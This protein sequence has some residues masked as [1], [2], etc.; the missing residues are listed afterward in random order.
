MHLYFFLRGNLP[1]VEMFKTLAQGQ[2]WQ[3][4]RTNI[5][6]NKEETILVQGVLRPSVFG[7]YEYVFPEES[8]PE[9]LS[10]LGY[11]GEGIPALDYDT[12]FKQFLGRRK[13]SI[14]RKIFG[15]K[16]IPK[17]VF[18]VA[19][20]I[21][22]SIKLEGGTRGLSHLKIPGVAVHVIG[23]KEDKRGEFFHDLEAPNGFRQE[24]L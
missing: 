16:A 12:A 7:S 22:H 23:I 4:K 17:K 3:W 19:K 1:C 20:L 2:Y 21:P 9:V 15:C 5:E 13:M 14:L 6:T 18:E 11:L 10:I 8:L 24:M